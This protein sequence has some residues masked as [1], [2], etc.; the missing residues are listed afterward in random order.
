MNALHDLAC[1]SVNAERVD[2]IF[3]DD[4]QLSTVEDELARQIV[5]EHMLESPNNERNE[6][7]IKGHSD[8]PRSQ[9]STEHSCLNIKGSASYLKLN[10]LCSST[11][12]LCRNMT[13]RKS[14][15]AALGVKFRSRGWGVLEI[16]FKNVP[17]SLQPLIERQ[18]LVQHIW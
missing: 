2:R 4:L 17:Q 3:D 6:Q 13:R 14:R 12:N 16:Y 11:L 7:Q 8:K 10:L 18:L 5:D 9:E 15:V 1:R